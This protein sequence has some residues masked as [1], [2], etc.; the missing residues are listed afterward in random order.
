MS[1]K[2]I[3][4]QYISIAR[5][6]V[7]RFWI[8]IIIGVLFGLFLCLFLNYSREILRFLTG[9]FSDLVHIESKD[10]LFFNIF[11]AAFST[12]IGFSVTFWFWI[13]GIRA[14]YPKE[15]L[16]T[17]LSQVNSSLSIWV[18]LL[19]VTRLGSVFF[20]L[21]YSQRGYDADLRLIEDSPLVFL[22]LPLV[23]FFQNWILIRKIFRT[24][25]WI[26]SSFIAF[27]S[28]SVIIYFLASI[29]TQVVDAKYQQRY[30]SEYAMIDNEVKR[31]K[32]QYN[33]T[34]SS[35][36]INTLK[37]W[38]ATSSLNQMEAVQKAFGS[39][40]DVALDSIIL[41]KIIVKNFKEGRSHSVKNIIENWP[42][43][44]P[45]EIRDQILKNKTDSIKLIELAALL[46]EQIDLINYY[47]KE[48]EDFKQLSPIERRKYLGVNY[49][50][51][52]IAMHQLIDVANEINAVIKAEGLGIELKE[53]R[54][55]DLE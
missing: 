29:D 13:S 44:K 12:A 32:D 2:F 54:S 18:P 21:L 33:I 5:I 35:A 34:Y 40:K 30:D 22:L 53:I 8:G 7:Y 6:G 9:E 20:I 1:P 42:Y 27:V 26:I 38:H 31:V 55:F 17:R 43:A 24:T 50:M 19:I 25:P 36:T 41:Q 52:K 46:N 10:S 16:F 45:Y 51:P 4:K 28:V 39:N 37:E 14:E 47:D 15:R 48:V 3:S 11:F 49:R 23:I